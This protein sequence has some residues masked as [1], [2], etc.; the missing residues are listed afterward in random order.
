LIFSKRILLFKNITLPFVDDQP[1]RHHE[2]AKK[3]RQERQQPHVQHRGQRLFAQACFQRV[4]VGFDEGTIP[5]LPDKGFHHLDQRLQFDFD[6]TQGR[7][8]VVG[9][10]FHLVHVVVGL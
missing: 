3:T 2:N 1:V 9:G 5:T 4:V 7:V 8:H 10:S 6:G